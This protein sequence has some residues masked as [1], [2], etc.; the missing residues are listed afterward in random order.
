MNV[1]S[2]ASHSH[3][4]TSYYTKNTNVKSEEVEGSVF[5]VG[6][7]EGNIKQKDSSAIYKGL[8]DKYDVKNA[9][10]EEIVEISNVLYEAGE[11]TFKE[12]IVLVFDYGRATN[13]LK[14]H[15]PGYVPADFDMYETSANSNGQ[16]D[17]ISEFGARAAKDFKFGN[18]VGYQSNTKVLDILERLSR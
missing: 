18:L 9:T 14:R 7:T 12:H 3:Q 11:I 6:E 8:S 1:N 15:A 4:L 5:L 13:N 2:I 17:W 10:F 16:R